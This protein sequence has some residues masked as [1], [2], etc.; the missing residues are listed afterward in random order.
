MTD[1]GTRA[2]NGHRNVGRLHKRAKSALDVNDLSL[3]EKLYQ[4]RRT[5]LH[6]LSRGKNK[7]DVMSKL[8]ISIGKVEEKLKI[9]VRNLVSLQDE[10]GKCN[11]DMTKELAEWEWY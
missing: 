4:N 2:R 5:V 10:L 9:Y 3:S 6:R 11:K 7:K 8:D 1:Y